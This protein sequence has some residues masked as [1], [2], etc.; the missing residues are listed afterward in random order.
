MS[1]DLSFAFAAARNRFIPLR[2]TLSETA[3]DPGA[4]AAIL[5]N[6]KQ[7]GQCLIWQGGFSSQGYYPYLGRGRFA[8]REASRAYNGS[9]EA[10]SIKHESESIEVHHVCH[11]KK[12]VNHC[13]WKR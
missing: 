6:T 5:K 13:T 1:V 3:A 12:C 11:D 2:W 7:A 9:L 4:L 10:G 8:H